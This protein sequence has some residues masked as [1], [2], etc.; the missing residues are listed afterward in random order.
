MCVRY[1]ADIELLLRHLKKKYGHL[2]N[3]SFI[4]QYRYLSCSCQHAKL[5][6]LKN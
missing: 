2:E 5:L 3:H 1:K 4:H 6:S